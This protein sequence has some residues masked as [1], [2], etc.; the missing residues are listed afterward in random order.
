MYICDTCRVQ[1]RPKN[2]PG[3]V[4]AVL[5]KDVSGFN[6]A[7]ARSLTE[8]QGVFF[9]ERCSPAWSDGYRRKPMPPDIDDG[10]E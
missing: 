1:V 7:G 3:I 9:H 10:D 6:P 2:E 4:F 8:G 5:L